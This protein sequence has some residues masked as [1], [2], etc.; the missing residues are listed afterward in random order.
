[1]PSAPID[2]RDRP[3]YAVDQFRVKSEYAS[4][5]QHIL[6]PEGEIKSRIE[7]L[8]DEI[9]RHYRQRDGV[10]LY[11][12]CVLKGAMRFFGALNPQLD[13]DGAYSEGVV[14]AARYTGGI[15]DDRTEVQWLEPDLI[16]GKDLLVVEDIIDKGV[17][18][19]AILE[20]LETYGPNSV[21]TAVLF[22]KP[23]RRQTDVEVG[24]T[25]FRIPD[26]FV[27]GFGLDYNERYRNL[28]HLGVLNSSAMES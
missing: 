7:G 20:Q 10:E 24:F 13:L 1:M 15:G 5:L 4:D 18:L 14:R 22:D 6:I 19:E 26:E 27:V 21:E 9:S 11:S 28:R 25:G 2:V 23:A 3:P 12:L 17:T 8:A 16:A